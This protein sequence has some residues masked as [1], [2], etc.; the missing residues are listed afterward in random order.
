MDY[1][2]PAKNPVR[3]GKPRMA[4]PC[5]LITNHYHLPDKYRY[6]LT[7]YMFWIAVLGLLGFA[8][9]IRNRYLSKKK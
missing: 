2:T 6:M 3:N 4:R 9:Y 5:T 8:Q 7:Y 1:A